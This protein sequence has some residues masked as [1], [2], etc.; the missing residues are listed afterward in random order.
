MG[1]I[2]IIIGREY[3]MGVRNKAFIILC[4][5]VPIFFAAILIVPTWLAS[6]PGESRKIVVC[7]N[8]GCPDSVGYAYVFRDTM[9]LT[10]DYS[11]V[12]K[13]IDEVR[14]VYADSDNVSVFWIPDNFMGG[15][16]TVNPHGVG[17]HTILY[18]KME[19][20]FNTLNYLESAITTQVQQDILAMNGLSPRVME[21]SKRKVAVGNVVNN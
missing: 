14:K 12:Y 21:L 8:S 9:N 18:S 10:F 5:A 17:M 1:K 15:C 19:P 13:P 6:Q 4:F 3:W 16:D 11:M 2:G 20:G 7:D